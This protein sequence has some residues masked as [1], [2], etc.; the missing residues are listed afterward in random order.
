MCNAGTCGQVSFLL[1]SS[2]KVIHK[3]K[4]LLGV[5]GEMMTLSK[6]L[7]ARNDLAGLCRCQGVLQSIAKPVRSSYKIQFSSPG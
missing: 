3:K 2:L 7:A 5:W 1:K 6:D 4:K